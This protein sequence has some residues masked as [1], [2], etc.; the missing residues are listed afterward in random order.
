MTAE[1]VEPVRTYRQQQW[2][3]AHERVEQ[4]VGD[5]FGWWCAMRVQG[6]IT[7]C[8][9]LSLAGQLRSVNAV[10]VMPLPLSFNG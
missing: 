2:R 1:P 6:R 7:S 9:D 3:D 5:L 10:Q 8:S 4:Q